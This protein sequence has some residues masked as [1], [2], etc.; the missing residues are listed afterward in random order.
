MN[1]EGKEGE[2]G[3]CRWGGGCLC[4]P[5]SCSIISQDSKAVC[6]PHAISFGLLDTNEVVC[7]PLTILFGLPDA[8]EAVCNPYTI[9]F[10][11]PDANEQCA[12]HTL[13]H[14]SSF[15]CPI[16]WGDSL[17]TMMGCCDGYH[18][19]PISFHLTPPNDGGFPLL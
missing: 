8:N 1:E 18:T 11:L 7:N 13:L 19:A 14:S 15:I 17:S 4:P 5:P 9:L 16:I 2:K 10:C 6:I 12:A 3:N